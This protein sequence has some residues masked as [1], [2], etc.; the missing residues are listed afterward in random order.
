M[1]DLSAN[2]AQLLVPSIFHL[3]NMMKERE[4]PSLLIRHSFWRVF[5]NCT[6]YRYEGKK[7]GST[8]APHMSLF[9]ERHNAQSNK[10]GTRFN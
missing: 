5:S 10:G 9:L 4:V 8:C 1:P 2:K 3:N 7:K 6:T